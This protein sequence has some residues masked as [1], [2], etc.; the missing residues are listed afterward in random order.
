VPLTGLTLG[1]LICDVIV[2]S[3]VA[4]ILS[5]AT[6]AQAWLAQGVAVANVRCESGRFPMHICDTPTSAFTLFLGEK[7]VLGSFI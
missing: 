3:P 6:P 7:P 2:V 1:V 4:K 5:F